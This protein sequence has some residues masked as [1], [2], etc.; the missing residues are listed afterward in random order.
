MG[1]TDGNAKVYYTLDGTLPTTNSPLYS[2]PLVLT[3]TIDPV[4]QQFETNFN[5]SV[6]AGTFSSSSRFR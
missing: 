4:R 6:A 5:N 3:N 2:G 1:A